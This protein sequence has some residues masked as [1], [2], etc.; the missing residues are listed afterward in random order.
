MAHSAEL[1]FELVAVFFHILG[2][3]VFLVARQN[4]VVGL[5]VGLRVDVQQVEAAELVGVGSLAARLFVGEDPRL[6]LEYIVGGAGSSV[7]GSLLF[8]LLVFFAFRGLLAEEGGSELVA[9]LLALKRVVVLRGLEGRNEL[10]LVVFG[11]NLLSFLH[12]LGPN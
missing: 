12:D 9:D 4:F 3:F 5:A 2:H 6:A 10:L 8:G 7:F 11:L 1:L